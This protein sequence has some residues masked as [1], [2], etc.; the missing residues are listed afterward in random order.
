MLA[1]CSKSYIFSTKN[2]NVFF[3]KINITCRFLKFFNK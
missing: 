3:K 1:M 2:D